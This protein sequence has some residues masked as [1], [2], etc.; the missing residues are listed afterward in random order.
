MTKA[1]L[2][3]I[4]K[5]MENMGLKYMLSEYK[6]KPSEEGLP[7]T[8]FVGEYQEIEPMNEDGMD[9]TAFILTGFSR[10]GINALEDAKEKIE[11][12]FPR[13]EGKVVKTGNGS[14]VAV[15]YANCFHLPTGNTEIKK[16]QINLTIKEW[17]V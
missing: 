6:V 12:C 5:H 9:E 4:A 15:F 2:G 11:A 8:Y 13:T 10:A 16:M 3:V 14:V 1:A 17:K 7:D